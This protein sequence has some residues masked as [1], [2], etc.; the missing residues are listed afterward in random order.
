ML[1]D[2]QRGGDGGGS[3][4]PYGQLTDRE[5]DVL[6]LV[7]EG[8]TTQEVSGMLGISPKTVEGH[9][10]NLMAKLDI[11]KRVDLVKYAIRKGIISV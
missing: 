2:S 5:R 8:F 9:T 6:K 7:A 4:D 1:E 3:R 11:H 10:T